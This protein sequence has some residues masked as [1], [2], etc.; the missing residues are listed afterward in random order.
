MYISGR[1]MKGHGTTSCRIFECKL[2]QYEEREDGQP[3]KEIVISDFPAILQHSCAPI[4]LLLS[5]FGVEIKFV[6]CYVG[7][8]VTQHT[9]LTVWARFRLRE[10]RVRV[11]CVSGPVVIHSRTSDYVTSCHDI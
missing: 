3:V 1:Y 4:L 7:T 5:L 6:H 8:V 2:A 10:A 11:P 9:R